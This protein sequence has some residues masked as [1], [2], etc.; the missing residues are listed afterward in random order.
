M[1][2]TGAAEPRISLAGSGALLL[3]AAAERFS[4]A[5]Q[6]RVW[7]VAAA[8]RSA[9]G[10]REVVPGMNNLLVV[11]DALAAAP[12]HVRESLR[13][14]WRDV[15]PGEVSGKTVEI[16][17]VYGGPRGE[18]LRDWAAHCGLAVTEAVQRHAAATYSVAAIGAMPGFPY[19]SGLDPAL[20]RPRRASPR[21]S[22]PEGAVIVGGAQ[23]GV[24]PQAAPSG[25]HVLGQTDVKLFDPLS[26]SPTLLLPGDVV[27]FVVAGIAE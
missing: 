7:A 26:D 15:E 25:W 8:M 5:V 13:A 22:I 6:E 2:M 24:M 20:A 9:A 3:D 11:F 12:Q 17:V 21:A 10:V 19:L 4:P 18:D 1:V 16:P 23:T 14:T 27:R